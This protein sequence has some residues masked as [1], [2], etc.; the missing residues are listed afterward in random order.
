MTMTANEFESAYAARSGVTVEWLC[1]H[2][3]VVVRC[4]CGADECE[5][6]A[7]VSKES[8]ADYAP[9]GIYYRVAAMREP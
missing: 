5:G 8:A 1:E 7:S 6:W 2:G 3:R 4:S 9:G